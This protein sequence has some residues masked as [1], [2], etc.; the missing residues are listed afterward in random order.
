ME[1]STIDQVDGH[2]LAILQENCKLPLV[3]IGERVGLSAPSVIDRIKK[4]EEAGIIKSY[5]AVLDS[6]RLGKDI[7]SFI[8]V[9][10][11]HPKLISQFEGEIDRFA[12]IQECHHVTGEYT[13]LLKV[14]AN[15]TSDLEEL[16]RK[17]RSLEGVQRTETTVVL[18]THTE[19]LRLSL[20]GPVLNGSPKPELNGASLAKKT[21]KRPSERK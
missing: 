1:H 8:G 4:L 11:N 12:E 17:I 10:I 19:G 3:K 2:I 18:S 5:T 21:S 20:P 9:S 7:T 6:K 14:K 13:L 16:I 15:S